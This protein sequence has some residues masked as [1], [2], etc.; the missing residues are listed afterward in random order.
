MGDVLSSALVVLHDW[1]ASKCA[2]QEAIGLD[3][4]LIENRLIDSLDFAEFLFLV[5]EVSGQEIDLTQVNLD[6]FRT[7]RSIHSRFLLGT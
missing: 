3:S 6:T 2:T 5:E 1:I 7:L 4:D